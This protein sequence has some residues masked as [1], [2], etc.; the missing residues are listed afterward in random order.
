MKNTSSFSNLLFVDNNDGSY[1][2]H[3]VA[4]DI[5]TYQ[6]CASFDDKRLSPCPFEV[7]VYSSKLVLS[8]SIPEYC[9]IIFHF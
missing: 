2:G 1:M 3:Y 8:Q 6:I 4:E 9:Q 7:N 5:G